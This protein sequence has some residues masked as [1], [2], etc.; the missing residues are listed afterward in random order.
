MEAVLFRQEHVAMGRHMDIRILYAGQE[1]EGRITVATRSV[2]AV[3]GRRDV[4]K[5][6]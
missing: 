1:V 5:H 3:L 4:R 6:G 2:H